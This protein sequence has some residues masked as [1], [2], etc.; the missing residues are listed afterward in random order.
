[1]TLVDDA[2]LKDS[3]P[4][5]KR[6]KTQDSSV[7]KSMTSDVPGGKVKKWHVFLIPMK[8]EVSRLTLLGVPE[9]NFSRTFFFF[10]KSWHGCFYFILEGWDMLL[11]LLLYYNCCYGENWVILPQAKTPVINRKLC[12]QPTTMLSWR[13]FT[14]LAAQHCAA[15]PF[16]NLT[17]CFWDVC[18]LLSHSSTYIQS[19]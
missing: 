16:C 1:M 10:F 14:C 8:S 4:D 7:G 15:S 17:G 2:E 3:E 12:L 13:A 9:Y 19:R 18:F 11:V 5:E 6:R